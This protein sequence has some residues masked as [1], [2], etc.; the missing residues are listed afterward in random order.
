MVTLYSHQCQQWVLVLLR[1]TIVQPTSNPLTSDY[2]VPLNTKKYLFSGQSIIN[3]SVQQDVVAVGY[4]CAVSLP[5]SKF[6]VL[7]NQP[8][9]TTT[10]TYAVYFE[11]NNSTS[12][13]NFQDING[14]LMSRSF[15]S[16]S[17]VRTTNVGGIFEAHNCMRSIENYWKTWPKLYIRPD[18][19]WCGRNVHC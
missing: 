18:Q 2:Q 17:T 8:S 11:N 7:E 1:V 15:R 14:G 19:Y 12:S 16:Q 9:Q 13:Q 6:S 4:N 3:N 5:L 10:E